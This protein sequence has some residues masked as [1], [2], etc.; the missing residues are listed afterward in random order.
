MLKVHDSVEKGLDA[1]VTRIRLLRVRERR[2]SRLCG[3][4]VVSTV[5]DG[6]PSASGR[7]TKLIRAA[8]AEILAHQPGRE[9]GLRG[10]RGLARRGV[11]V[12]A[13][14]AGLVAD[15]GNQRAAADVGGAGRERN[16]RD[17]GGRESHRRGLIRA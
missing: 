14:Q 13:L 7:Q 17:N 3:F 16:E 10:F 8:V 9:P 12:P 6:P 4:S 1:E 2:R 15:A 11:A 5:I